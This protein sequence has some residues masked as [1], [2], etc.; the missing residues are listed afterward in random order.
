MNTP[1]SSGQGLKDFDNLPI[2]LLELLRTFTQEI[3]DIH[4]PDELLWAVTHKAISQLGLEDC[5]IYTYDVQRK[6]LIQKA[7]HGPKAKSKHAISAPIEIALN[8]GIVGRV[9]ATLQPSLINDTREVPEYIEDD[10]RRLSELTVPIN[11]GDRLLGIIDSE[12]SEAGF[13]D[14]SDQLIL[15]TIASI[16]A[17]KLEK[18]LTHR[19]S[20][21]LSLFYKRNPNPVLQ[22]DEHRCI[23]IINSSAKQGLGASIQPGDQLDKEGLEEAL[24]TAKANGEAHWEC[25]LAIDPSG[26]ERSAEF[27][28]IPLPNGKFNLYGN[29][30]THILALKKAAEAANEAKSKFLSVMSHEIRTPLNAILGLTNLLIHENPDREEQMRHLAYMEFSG[31]HLLSLVNDIL[32]LEKLASGKDTL[33]ITE[34]QL[35]VLIN[36]IIESF[37]NRAEKTGL[38]L[39]VE[40]DPLLPD[41]IRTDVK[42]LTQILNNLLS[43]AIKY[44]EKGE[45]KLTV[46]PVSVGMPYVDHLMFSIQDTGKGIPALEIER[47]LLP[48][49]QIRVNPTIEGT[50]LGLAIVHS[51]VQKMNGT[52]DITSTPGIGS[53]FSVTIPNGLKEASNTAGSQQGTIESATGA[54]A[55]DTVNQSGKQ[56]EP[57]GPMKVVIADDNELNRFVARKLLERWGFEAIKAEDGKEAFE[58]WQQH[59][60]CIVLMDVQMPVMDGIEATRKIREYEE[61]S[62]VV[63]RSPIIAL[64][65]DAEKKT[66][67]N[68]I[69]AGMDDRII[70]PFDPPAL[71]ALLKHHTSKLNKD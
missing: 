42:W 21:A 46:K 34:F 39:H 26:A 25:T 19:E 66:M 61:E 36:S 58:A 37:R 7:A 6:R 5:V 15:E 12:H 40:I 38:A 55:S 4:D 53:T 54:L 41:D 10:A 33:V 23:H 62:R 8:E 68:I 57:S 50:G 43:N 44:T 35:K 45:V 29:E 17:T 59:H 32:D 30:V 27:K 60:P 11:I 18:A 56:E 47:I 2:R 9:A 1:P 14:M 64:T 71:Q 69:A 20:E 63:H 3:A 24:T 51:L 48:F 49:E 13:F 67:L 31:S 65:A 70:K 16:T 52:L 28:V 22:I